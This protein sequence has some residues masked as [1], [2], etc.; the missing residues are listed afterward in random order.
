MVYGKGNKGIKGNGQWLHYVIFLQF[1]S[2]PLD[3]CELPTES[4][5][6]CQLPT[7]VNCQLNQ[8]PSVFTRWT[9]RAIRSKARSSFSI[10]VA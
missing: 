5:L 4:T 3:S 1:P 10:E 8:L 2:F 9:K 7:E 6:N